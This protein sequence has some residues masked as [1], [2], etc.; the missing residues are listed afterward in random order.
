MIAIIM[1]CS[2]FALCFSIIFHVHSRFVRCDTTNGILQLRSVHFTYRNMVLW[3][4]FIIRNDIWTYGCD[5][6]SYWRKFIHFVNLLCVWFIMLFRAMLHWLSHKLRRTCLAKRYIVLHSVQ[7]HIEILSKIERHWAILRL[8][9]QI[10]FQFEL[11]LNAFILFKCV[12][13]AIASKQLKT[14][15]TLQMTA[16]LLL[17]RR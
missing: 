10:Q 11:K 12:S 14:A 2:S 9:F 3:L 7:F 13:Q 5:Y 6:R 17:Q 4:L 8:Q 15:S 16:D 1:R